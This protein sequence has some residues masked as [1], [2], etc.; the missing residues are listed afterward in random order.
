MIE[1]VKHEIETDAK[2]KL[3]KAILGGFVGTFVFTL[4]GMYLAPIIL[5]HAMDTAAMLA[6]VFG[7]SYVFGTL[8]H[9]TLGSII[10]PVAYLVVAF[11]RVPGPAIFRGMF[12][13]VALWAVAMVVVVPMM[14]HP[15]FMGAVPPAMMSLAGHI[16]YGFFLGLITGKSTS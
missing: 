3:L 7:G 15:F 14:G 16:V 10:F 1:T 12:W 11:H 4:M 13:G 8:V 6:P 5:G 2:E 9:F